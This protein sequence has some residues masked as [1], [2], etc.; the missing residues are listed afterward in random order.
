MTGADAII[1]ALHRA[2][3]RRLFGMPGGGSTADLMEAA[4]LAG[5]PFTLA[6]T[7]AGAAFMATAQAE[8]TGRPAAAV[9]TLGPGAASLM[10]GV[11]NAALD[12]VPLVVVTDCLPGATAAF[13]D[14]QN[15]P[16]AAIFGPLTKAS[17]AI[18]PDAPGQRVA[19]ALLT[20]TNGC[21]GPVHLDVS[22]A[23]TAAD[24]PDV[25]DERQTSH[26]PVPHRDLS[27]TA[28]R[29]LRDSRR[30]LLLIGL[31][32]CA[33]DVAHAVRAVAS[34]HGVPALVT[35]KAKGVIPDADR[36]WAGVL[37]HGALERPM[38]EDA[39]LFVAIGLDPVELLP[40][41]W[42]FP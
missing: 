38:L 33:D 13:A 1:G 17:V 22:P 31:G 9:A 8:I 18:G 29:M 20:A 2:G 19:D 35:Y 28:R 11:A 41:A 25:P 26:G 40:R 16:H 37:T 6:Q 42:T 30:P 39:D 32:A 23:V 3:V 27:A 15:V 10:N 7:E 14:H 12:R 4:R 24:V 5:L 21:P 36:W 34:R